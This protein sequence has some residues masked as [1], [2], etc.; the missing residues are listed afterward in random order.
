MIE[1]IHA[2]N[3]EMIAAGVRKFAC[4]ISAAGSAKTLRAHPT[5]RCSSPDGPYTETKEHMGGFWILECADIDE[6]LDWAKRLPSPAM[7][8]ARCAN[9]FSFR[10]PMEQRNSRAQT[11][12]RVTGFTMIDRI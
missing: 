4:G 2:L 1:E 6:A 12:T 3:R 8:P 5:A 9:F 10:V 7:G 11:G